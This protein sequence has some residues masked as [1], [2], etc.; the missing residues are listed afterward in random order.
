[1]KIV[2]RIEE[3]AAKATPGPFFEDHGAIVSMNIPDGK[4]AARAK[5]V[6]Y[7]LDKWDAELIT[8]LLNNWPAIREVLVAAESV[9]DAYERREDMDRHHSVPSLHTAIDELERRDV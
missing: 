6:A 4:Q 2:E 9:G 7:D 3:L 5:T 1:M 8:A